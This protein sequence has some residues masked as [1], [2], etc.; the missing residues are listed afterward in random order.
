MEKGLAKKILAIGIMVVGLAAIVFAII[1]WSS[2][3]YFYEGSSVRFETYGGDAYTGI[4]NAAAQTANNIQYLNR[5]LEEFA[6]LMANWMGFL[7]ITIGTL[8]LVVGVSKTISAFQ[9]KPLEV[10]NEQATIC[11]S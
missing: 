1:C 6:T 11:N 5:S 2:S 4:Q 3:I 7:L 8:L 9:K 10:V